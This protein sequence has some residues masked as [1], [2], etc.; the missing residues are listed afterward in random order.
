MYVCIYLFVS[1]RSQRYYSENLIS[2]PK[3]VFFKWLRTSKD[4]SKPYNSKFIAAGIGL[5]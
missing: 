3:V 1:F 2:P 5:E 4:G